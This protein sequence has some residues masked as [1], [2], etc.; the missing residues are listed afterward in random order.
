MVD[1]NRLSKLGDC[2]NGN[3][4]E[5]SVFAGGIGFVFS[6]CIRGTAQLVKQ[7]VLP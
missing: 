2:V 1:D 7:I 3:P 5:H 6:G 4:Y